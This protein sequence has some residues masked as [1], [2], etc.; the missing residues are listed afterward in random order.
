[1]VHTF[2]SVG[3][4]FHSL[5]DI[6]LRDDSADERQS[7]INSSEPEFHVDIGRQDLCLTREGVGDLETGPVR[8][9]KRTP[10]KE[11]EKSV[12]TEDV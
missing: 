6:S 12:K 2:S 1:M 3:A 4:A 5:T 10:W 7:P 11:R 8:V 9:R